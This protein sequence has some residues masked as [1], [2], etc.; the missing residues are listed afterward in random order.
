MEYIIIT[1]DTITGERGAFE[2]DWFDE[3]KWNPDCM[4]AVIMKYKRMITFDGETW[5][6]IEQDH[7]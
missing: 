3:E 6:D 1:Q 2:T 4:I 5:D 7:L